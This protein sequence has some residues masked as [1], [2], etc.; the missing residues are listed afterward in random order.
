[1]ALGNAPTS[2]EVIDALQTRTDHPSELVR[3]HVAWAIA[4]HI[5]H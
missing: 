3:E 4:Q 2:R 1:V 5:V